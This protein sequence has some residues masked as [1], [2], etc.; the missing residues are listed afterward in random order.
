ME[1]RKILRFKDEEGEVVSLEAI[2]EIYLEETKYLILAPMDEE[3]SDEFVYR[4]DMTKEGSE[5]LNAVDDDDEFM[6]VKK[7]YKNLL[8]GEG[9]KDE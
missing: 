3:S 5:E 4:V 7:E 8:Y 2:A 1:E 6:Q 9:G